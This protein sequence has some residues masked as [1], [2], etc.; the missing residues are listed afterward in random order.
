MVTITYVFHNGNI[1]LKSN[2]A[3]KLS[4]LK[5]N[6]QVCLQTEVM[7]N[8]ANWRNVIPWEEFENLEGEPAQKMG[9]D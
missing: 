9:L 7:E 2:E 4:M 8:M 1:Y 5:I 6:P 3:L